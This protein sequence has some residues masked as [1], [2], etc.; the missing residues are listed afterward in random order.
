MHKSF[1][2]KNKKE[3]VKKIFAKI[4]IKLYIW[5]IILWRTYEHQI[6]ALFS[7]FSDARNE[8]C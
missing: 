4:I 6:I 5:K 8:R 3:E 2:L 1:F 7:S